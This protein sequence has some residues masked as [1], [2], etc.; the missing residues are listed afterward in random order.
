[1][2]SDAGRDGYLIWFSK[3]NKLILKKVFFTSEVYLLT[4]M[5]IMIPSLWCPYKVYPVSFLPPAIKMFLS[6]FTKIF[7]IPYNSVIC[8]LYQLQ[9]QFSKLY[10]TE[11]IV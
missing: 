7:Q 6:S 10:D 9:T 4:T 11:Q 5:L 1:M 8:S 3:R 2:E